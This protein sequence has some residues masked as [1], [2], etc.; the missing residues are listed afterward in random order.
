MVSNFEF[1]SFGFVSIFGFRIWL[2]LRRAGHSRLA[3]MTPEEQRRRESLAS[4][5]LV[6]ELQREYARIEGFLRLI[7]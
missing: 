5:Y 3:S 4:F 6:L 1:F 2:R 7:G